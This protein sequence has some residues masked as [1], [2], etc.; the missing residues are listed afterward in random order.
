MS[1]ES[2]HPTLLPNLRFDVESAISMLGEIGSRKKPLAKL[3]FRVSTDSDG[4]KGEVLFRILERA[5][6]VYESMIVPEIL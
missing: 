3:T 2:V 5:L 1:D 4:E 6:P